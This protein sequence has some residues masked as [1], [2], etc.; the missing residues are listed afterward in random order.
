MS[1]FYQWVSRL[2]R[3]IGKRGDHSEFPQ[4]PMPTRN[5]HT[6]PAFYQEFVADHYKERGDTVWEY[7]K[8]KGLEGN[9]INLVIKENR[10]IF[11]I[12]TKEESS[13]ITSHDIQNF[14]KESDNFLKTHP[15][16]E[17]YSIQLLYAMPSLLLDEESYKY[18]KANPHIGYKIVK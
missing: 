7:S 6:D 1:N 14:E 9:Q 11:L 5:T 15:I 18:I 8:E 10:T 4:L 2:L 12:H 17:G 16:F 3:S 13:D